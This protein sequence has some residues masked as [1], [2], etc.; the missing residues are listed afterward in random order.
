MSESVSRSHVLWQGGTRHVHHLHVGHNLGRNL[1]EHLF[2]ELTL[3]TSLVELNELDDVAG[4]RLPRRVA[5]LAV[6][7]VE[8]HHRFKVSIA[9]SDNDDRDREHGQLAD[10]IFSLGHVVNGA[11]SEQEQDVVLGRA[12]RRRGKVEELLQ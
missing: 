9:D 7:T 1:F 3:G 2:S 10:Q 5:K 12:S 4:A 6:V 8:L 11:I